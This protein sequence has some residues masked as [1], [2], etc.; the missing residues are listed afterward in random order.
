MPT[1]TEPLSSD[2]TFA[3]PGEGNHRRRAYVVIRS[4]RPQDRLT[5]PSSSGYRPETGRQ[6]FR[7]LETQGR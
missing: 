1:L 5:E 3:G 2:R 4:L 7:N 6:Y